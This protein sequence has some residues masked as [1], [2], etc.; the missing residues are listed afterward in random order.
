MGLA[1]EAL[2]EEIVLT[3]SGEEGG[4]CQSSVQVSSICHSRI[5]QAATCDQIVQH[6]VCLKM[7]YT[8]VPNK[9]WVVEGVWIQ[10]LLK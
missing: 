4:R 3:Q 9:V 8:F 2:L 1:R 5:K 7:V 6:I 10:N